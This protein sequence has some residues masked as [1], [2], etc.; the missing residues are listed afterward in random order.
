MASSRR[1]LL[2]LV[3]LLRGLLSI[4]AAVIIVIAAVT[5]ESVILVTALVSIVVLGLVLG[6]C[7][8]QV[9]LSVVDGSD[10]DFVNEVLSDCFFHEGN[11][12]EAFTLARGRVPNNLR[13]LNRAKV[14][15]KVSSEIF[16]SEAIV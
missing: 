5:A 13:C 16:L 3:L 8:P 10:T 1:L 14:V 2:R 12:A 15:L 7:G 6:V 9:N 11:E 4:L